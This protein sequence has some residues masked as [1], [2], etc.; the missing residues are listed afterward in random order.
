METEN[1]DRIL[2][3]DVHGDI[4]TDVDFPVDFRCAE[5]KKVD[6]EGLEKFVG[7]DVQRGD[8]TEGQLSYEFQMWEKYTA[9]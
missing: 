2:F 1:C 5:W 9:E 4:E 7:G 8:I 3:T 6:H